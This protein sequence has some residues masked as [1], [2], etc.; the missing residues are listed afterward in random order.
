MSLDRTLKAH[1]SLKGARSVMTRAERIA[2]MMDEGR[3][4][5]EKDS[6]L[7]LPKLRVRHS[8]AGSKTK[9]EAPAEAAAE[10]AEGAEGEAPEA[11]ADGTK[12]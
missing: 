8:K 6:P 7:G 11:A 2:R 1:G 10:G 9:K 3:F 4:D 5:P 12:E